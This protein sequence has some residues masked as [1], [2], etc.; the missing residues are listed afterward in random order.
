MDDTRE[1]K[2]PGCQSLTGNEYISRPSEVTKIPER[3]LVKTLAS[4]HQKK[5][6]F[7]Q[8]EIGFETEKVIIM[9]DFETLE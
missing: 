9:W 5:R 4:E 1:Q 7:Y 2:V 3:N 6:S 8:P